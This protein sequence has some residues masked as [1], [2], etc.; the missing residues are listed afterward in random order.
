M[1]TEYTFLNPSL[2]LS[3]YMPLKEGYNVHGF[4]VEHI[5]IYKN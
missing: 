1:R 3:K 5:C 2:I 4:E